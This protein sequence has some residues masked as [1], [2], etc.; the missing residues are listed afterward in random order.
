MIEED[1][2]VIAIKGEIAEVEAQ[3]R[4][5]CGSCA[6]KGACGTSLLDRFLGRRPL[7]LRVQ[8]DLGANLGD[9][10][11]IGVPES[12]LLRAAVAAYLVPLL[13]LILGAIGGQALAGYMSFALTELAATLG[14]LLGFLL[15]LRWLSAHSRR[16]AVDDRY[17][18]VM[19]RRH[20][21]AGIEVPL[22]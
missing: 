12:A 20:A 19:L 16:L 6:A 15:S 21:S 22:A 17:R 13:A 10:V 14:G 5:S 4:G 1:A 9:L 7:Q 18:A 3:R 2:R 11:V 8:N